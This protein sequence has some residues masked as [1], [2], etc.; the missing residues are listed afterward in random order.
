MRHTRAFH[1]AFC[2]LVITV[3]IIFAPPAHSQ[4][5]DNLDTVLKKMDTASSAFRTTEASFE[6]ILWEKVTGDQDTQKGKVY[7]RREGS[8]IEMAAD[9][10]DP[11]PPKYLLFTGDKIELY[12]TGINR[13]TIFDATQ[14]RAD[15][16]T[17]LVLGFGGSGHDLLKSFDV[18]YK[19]TEKIGDVTASILDLVPKSEK[20][21]NNFP[22]I[23]LWID[24][25]RGLSIQQ[26]LFES[27]GNYRQQIYSDIAI[28]KKIADSVFKLKTNSKTETIMRSGS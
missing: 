19:G 21:R 26:K 18:T 1:S 27:S 16:E 13:V 17:F 14:H 4:S 20:I 28:N 10:S 9:V 23:I 3:A 2:F 8:H 6:W 12:E 24:P 25:D 5:A 11:K 15:F 22:H 7:F